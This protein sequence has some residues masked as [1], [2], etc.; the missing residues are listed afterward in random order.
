M[1]QL[2]GAAAALSRTTEY[3]T[4]D[5]RMN[6]LMAQKRKTIMDLGAQV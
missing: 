2:M 5:I 6:G 1:G 3:E 4:A